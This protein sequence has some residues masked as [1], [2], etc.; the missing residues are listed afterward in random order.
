MWPVRPIVTGPAL[1][2]ATNAQQVKDVTIAILGE[3]EYY[4][5]SPY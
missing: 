3:D 1:I 2:D 4:K 5:A